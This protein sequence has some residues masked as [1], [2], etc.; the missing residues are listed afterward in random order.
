MV[1]SSTPNSLRFASSAAF[2]LSH[3]F[4][5]L[6][7]LYATS[8]PPFNLNFL[9]QIA[10]GP[11]QLVFRPH[12]PKVMLF[13]IWTGKD[14][15]AMKT[16]EKKSGGKLVIPEEYK[17]EKMEGACLSCERKDSCCQISGRAGP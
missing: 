13:L 2:H 16:L 15:A 8:F 17:E 3:S 1:S 5:A 10:G 7:L 14:F 6:A 4:S 9:I 11:R 12:R